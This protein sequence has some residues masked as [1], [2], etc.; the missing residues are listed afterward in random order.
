MK[1]RERILVALEAKQPDR[2]PIFELY[3]NE[4][5]IVRLAQLL[6]PGMV[7]VEAQKDRFGEERREILDLYCFLVDELGLDATCT[8]FSI[9]IEIVGENVG[10]D[11]YGTIYRLSEHGEPMPIEGPIQGPEDL[12][13]FDMVSKLHDEDFSGVRHVID[14][15]GPEKAHFISV[16]DPFKVSWRRRGGMQHLLMDYVLRP[17]FVHDLA[18]ISTDFDK[19]AID[20]AVESG[21]DVV[22]VPGDLA[23]EL[24]TIMSPQHYREYIKPYH[25]EMVDHAH[26]RG[27]KIVKHSDGNVWPI[28]DDLLEVGFDGIHPIQ[29][30]CMDVAEVKEH[31]A[32]R[33]CILGNIDCREL[34]PFGTEEEV[35]ATVRE[36]IKK[37]APGGGYIISSSNSI[38]PGCKAQNYVA[39]VRAAHEYGRYS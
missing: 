18:R 6:A 38:H 14:A 10:R 13:G 23:G 5:S 11:K 36:T 29:P 32:G 26:R 7:E 31:V 21:V 9:G 20:M 17:Q 4:S 8:N 22:I 3:I 28:L 34:L 19:A 2:V 37:A 27:V 35:E 16:T 12:V 33:A 24:T 1:S 25:R 30:Q 39:M 15:V